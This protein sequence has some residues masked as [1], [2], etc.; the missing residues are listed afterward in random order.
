M[1]TKKYFDFYI[2][3]CVR[4]R[5]LYFVNISIFVASGKWWLA[6]CCRA[7]SSETFHT[8]SFFFQRKRNLQNT[9]GKIKCSVSFATFRNLWRSL[10]ESKPL[11]AQWDF[12]HWQWIHWSIYL[13]LQAAAK[14]W[15]DF[16]EHSTLMHREPDKKKNSCAL[17][18]HTCKDGSK[19]KKTT[20]DMKKLPR[21]YI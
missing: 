6:L 1:C 7:I 18:P 5:E 9:F 15:G 16:A 14:A 19:Y 20:R 4:T 12:C 3:F 10:F 2:D 11:G 8:S 21:K 17:K 13:C